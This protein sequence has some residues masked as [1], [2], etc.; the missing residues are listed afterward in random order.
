MGCRWSEVQ[1]LSP[2]PDVQRPP[3]GGSNRA[4]SVF[5]CRRSTAPRSSRCSGDARIELREQRLPVEQRA[6]VV[7]RL[8]GRAAGHLQRARVGS[9]QRERLVDELARP[10]G[11]A[12]ALRH[13]ERVGQLAPHLRILRH[14][15]RGGERASRRRARRHRSGRRR[16]AGAREHPAA[17][18]A[19]RA[20]E[21]RFERRDQRR[22]PGAGR[23]GRAPPRPGARRRS[24]PPPAAAARAAPRARRSAR[25]LTWRPA[26]PSSRRRGS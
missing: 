23:A 21:V 22:V 11:E 17:A 10:A 4:S 12:A 24:A 9:P 3:P 13:G 5:C 14:L 15:A 7:A 26:S 6:F 2:R 20:R 19:R 16:S 25:R 18:V 1:I 8:V